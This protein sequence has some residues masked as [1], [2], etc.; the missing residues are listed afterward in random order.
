MHP[1]EQAIRDVHATWI[2]AVNAGDLAELQGLMTRDAVFMNPGRAAIGP[3]EFP[4]GFGRA[5]RQFQVRCTS[6]PRDIAISGDLAVVCSRDA[7]SLLPREDGAPLEMA[8]DRL[9]VYRR[10]SDGRW[11]LARDAHTLSPVL[12]RDGD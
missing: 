10:E 3:A 1:D 9:T 4:S 12:A 2:A 5:Q 7:L 8:G 6:E 11:R